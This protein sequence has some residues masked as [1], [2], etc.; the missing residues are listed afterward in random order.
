MRIAVGSDHRGYHAR[1]HIIGYLKERE[2]EVDDCGSHS[3]ESVDYPDI[4][5]EV[6]GK[7]ASGQSDRG[8]L[9]CGTGLGMCLAAN[10]FR[11]I[12]ATAVQDDI[13]AELS[14]THNDSNILC[15]SADLLGQPL[16]DHILDIWLNTEFEGGRHARRL[17]KIAEIEREQC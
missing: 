15:L 16:M 7:V 11:G 14:R 9:V 5:K 13:T 17:E 1:L 6:A 3:E 8:V 4:A 2:H 12:R 10:K